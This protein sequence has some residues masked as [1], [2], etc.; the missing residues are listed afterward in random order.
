MDS[1][2]DR[3]RA[4]RRRRFTLSRAPPSREARMDPVR[5][6]PLR[7]QPPSEVLRAHGSRT[8]AAS[9][10]DIDVVG[11]LRRG[12][13]SADFRR[14]TNL[15]A[16]MSLRRA[17]S[18]RRY[19]RF[20]GNDPAGD[21]DDELRFHLEARYDEYV[22]DGMTPERARA[23]VDRRFG[24]VGTVRARCT[25]IDTQWQRERSMIDRFHIAATELRFAVRQLRRNTSLSI[26][27]IL[28]LALGIGVNTSI[29]SVVDTLLFR[30][31]P[32]PQSD[33]LVLIGEALPNFGG[34][35]FGLISTPEYHDYQR[36]EGRVF[37]SSAIY[38]NTAL[39]ISSSGA[40]PERVP[41]AVVSA[42]LFKVLRINPAHGRLFLP[43]DDVVGSANTAVISDAFW[44][45]RFNADPSV[46]G[47]T[48]LV[49]GVAT[50][51]VGIT[52]SG[53]AFPLPG[54]GGPVADIFSPY[55]IT[56]EIEKT[57]GD[58]YSTTLIAR[59]APGTTLEQAKRGASEIARQLPQRHPDVYSAKHV[60][61]AD[62]F[63]LRDRA[64][65]D[66]RRS[67]LVLFASV[68]LVLLIACIN[69]SS[70]LLA[71]AATR[72]REISVRR[73][74]GAS[75][76]RL[77]M[78]FLAESSVLVMIGGV[79]GVAFATWGAKALAARAP[80]ALLQGYQIAVN[81]RVLLF[82]VVI[83]A[84]TA[85][86]VS[87]LPALQ[88]PEAGIAD[89]LQ[90]GGRTASA[91]ISKQRGRRTLVVSEIA[92]ALI[93]ATGAGLMV[94]S[95]INTQNVDPGFDSSGLVSFRLG[96]LNYRYRTAD[97]VTRF[98]QQM[99]DRL[100]ALPGVRS[101]SVATTIPMSGG[102]RISF[103]IEGSD[104][105]KVP[106]ASNTIVFPDYFETLRIPIRAGR[107]FNQQ[108]TR[109]SPTVAIINEALARQY[110]PGV[111]PVGRRI[112]WGSP[113]SP[114]PW[115]TIVGVSATVKASS[116][117]SPD[118]PAVYFPATQ[119][120]TSIVD[121]MMRGMVYLVRTD[122]DPSALFNAIRRTVKD[123]DPE[124]PIVG[125]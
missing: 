39:T 49:N 40:D 110:Y 3:R 44:R 7:E 57:R 54:L 124:L 112:K 125:L 5:L 58:S 102:S 26:A 31:L 121:R 84:M 105:P 120:D 42:T 70:L 86:V 4:P 33:R 97:E 83:A 34:G 87:L 96:L 109:S 79:L 16:L 71:R 25:E 61:T 50:T 90:G 64:I 75:R 32:F 45:R 103:S 107:S 100:G 69:V 22:A 98:E 111:N 19:L 56:P 92:L 24:D 6:G 51:I 72:Q 29:F 116:L 108:D 115:A 48:I 15:G 55:W 38:E 93:V 66:S 85:V 21:L 68:G 28:C 63:P 80:Q 14:P 9:R 104:L 99:A 53:F 62:V 106:I 60:T 11:V 101:A 74:L 113:T 18:W 123:A 10:R 12:R 2:S 46:V 17:A 82:S 36:L 76:S 23:E 88:R 41:S 8:A 37:E 20:W 43:G 81:G 94:K 91:G 73:A 59:L 35:N 1:A 77:A 67:L 65:G 118:E 117:E 52:P 114:S 122:G 78:Q 89:S 47:R 30:P 27:A 95:L 119:I 13:Q